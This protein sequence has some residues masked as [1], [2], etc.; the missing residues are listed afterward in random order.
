MMTDRSVAGSAGLRSQRN[1]ELMH[2]RRMNG[3]DA[4]GVTEH[5]DEV[6]QEKRGQ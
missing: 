4:Y 5:F 6:D 3:H 2:N 1:I